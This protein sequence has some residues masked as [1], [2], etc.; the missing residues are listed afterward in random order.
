MI[1]G[2]SL[3]QYTITSI[4]LG[5]ATPRVRT[6][7]REALNRTLFSNIRFE[8]IKHSPATILFHKKYQMIIYQ[9]IIELAL[10]DFKY[11]TPYIEALSLFSLNLELIIS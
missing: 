3:V 4:G 11:S 10:L 6:S 1:E 2:T 8:T 7:P 9:M 5:R